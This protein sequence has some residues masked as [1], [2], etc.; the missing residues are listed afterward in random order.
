MVGLPRIVILA[1]TRIITNPRI[2]K[3]PAS[4]EA[5]FARIETLVS[6]PK[7]I[8]IEPGPNHWQIFRRLVIESEVIGPSMTDAFLASLAIEHGSTLCSHD[9][10]FRRFKH[11]KFENP[12]ASPNAR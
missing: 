9:N 1:Y 5:A 11:L 6:H 8:I 10:G 3:V 12:H 4:A 2:M 7:T